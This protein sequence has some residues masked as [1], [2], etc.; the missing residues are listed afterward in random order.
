VVIVKNNR[1]LV[2]LIL[3]GILL[4]SCDRNPSEPGNEDIR[5]LT[6]VEKN[7]V[8]SDNIFGLKLFQTL[9]N[10][11]KDKNVFISP[12]SIAMALGMTLNGAD[13]ETKQAMQQTLEVAGLTDEQINSSYKSLIELLTGM[14]PKVQFQIANSIWYS[15][16]FAVEQPFIDVNQQYF[17]SEVRALDFMDPLSVNVI[18]SWVSDNTQNKIDKIIDQINPMTIMFLIN[19]IYFKGIWTYQFNEENTVNS[20]FYLTDSTEKT[21]PLMKVAGTFNYY[22][23]DKLKAVDLPY[24]D[25]NF[26]MTVILPKSGI[27]VENL[28]GELSQI[29]WNNWIGQLSE[30]EGEIYLPRFKLEYKKSLVEILAQLG[31][32]IAFTSQADFTRINSAGNLFISE[33]KHKSFVEV[34]EEGTEAAAITSVEITFTA[35]GS[36]FVFRA[37]RPFIF[38]IR[39]KNSGTILFIGKIV[40]PT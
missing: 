9:I 28:I 23:N 38:V 21:C 12:L 32:G 29:N 16:S 13:G 18:N 37:N 3:F 40:D 27:E 26:S 4:V 5:D 1:C 33:V 6:P 35:V 19:A 11:E 25:K 10:D 17:N 14:D 31:M 8:E 24:G 39:E 15:S 34:N 7:I 20:P 36:G 30:S 22:S 2:L